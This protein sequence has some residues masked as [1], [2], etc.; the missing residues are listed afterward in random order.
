MTLTKQQHTPRSSRTLAA[1]FIAAAFA[2]AGF[3]SLGVWQVERLAWKEALL[4]RVARHVHAVPAPAPGPADWPHL[5]READEYRRLSV[6]GRFAHERETLVR[7]STELG[8]GYWVL[9]PLQTDQGFWVLVNR[10]FVP[11]E[12]SARAARQTPEPVGEQTV[13]G[14]LRLSEPGGSLLQKND[15]VHGRW[16]SRDVPAMAAAQGLSA[17]AVAPYFI[18]AVV[19]DGQGA[20]T[21]WPRRGLTVLQFS[22]NHLVY[23]LTWFALAAMTAGAMGYLVADERRLRRL[24]GQRNKP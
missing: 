13:I 7:A 15:A 2:L 24:S 16:Y 11:T 4:A 9:T 17:Q 6:R 21:S 20:D 10:G 1:I 5:Q 14:L 3:L 23:A 8:S 12:M 19:P 18:D 22:N